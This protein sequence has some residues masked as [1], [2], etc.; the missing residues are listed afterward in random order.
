MKIDTNRKLGVGSALA[1]FGGIGIALG[2]TIW[3]SASGPWAFGVGFLFGV[4]AGIGV[5]LA[6]VGLIELRRG[7]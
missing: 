7:A 3:A 5:A 4:M 6:V 1:V 2:P